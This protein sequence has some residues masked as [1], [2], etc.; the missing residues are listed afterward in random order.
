MKRPSYSAGALYAVLA[1][2]SLLTLAPFAWAVLTSLK[3]T[4]EIAGAGHIWPQA[5]TLAAYETILHGP[6]YQW[7]WNSF[8]VALAVTLLNVLFNTMAGYALA[9][10]RFRGRGLLFQTLMLLV[11]VPSQ[12]TMI[13][14]YMIVARM[15]LVDTHL[16]VILTSAVS[17]A[18]IFMMR[19]F[20]I[21]FPVE[22]EEAAT[23]DGSGPF[24][25]FFRIVL[26]MAKPA[27]AT[28]AIFVFMG[29]WNEFMKPL[30]FISS[31]DQY[32][33]T[34]GLNAVAKQYA[35]ASSWNLIMAGSVISIL[36]ILIMYIVLNRHFLNINDQ[37]SG[38]K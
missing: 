21:S 12:V 30:L 18:Y 26:P 13:P 20:F 10:L 19:Q 36:P 8:T 38:I 35:K 6:F 11:M 5:P 33:L 23:L 29:I 37:S 9:R 3:T 1:G 27:L 25:R 4:R 2:Y 7:L 14:A 24:H 34:Q 22:I 16:S 28:Q 17:I 32:L 15:G 31:V